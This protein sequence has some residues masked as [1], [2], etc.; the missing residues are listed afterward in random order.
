MV[1]GKP[2]NLGL[3]VIFCGM[4]YGKNF[5]PREFFENR[6]L[7]VKKIMTDYDRWA[8]HKR[9][10]LYSASVWWILHRLRTSEPSGIRR[11]VLLWNFPFYSTLLS[12]F[13]ITVLGLQLFWLALSSTYERTRKL[14]KSFE[15]DVWLQY[16]TYRGFKW[17]KKFEVFIRKKFW[18][19]TMCIKIPLSTKIRRMFCAYSSWAEARF[20]SL[21]VFNMLM[22][23]SIRRSD[24]SCPLSTSSQTQKIMFHFV[25]KKNHDGTSVTNNFCD[26]P[27]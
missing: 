11:F 26:E 23:F 17:P 7:L 18:S 14:T 15:N 2:I 6:T 24:K 25:R 12:R 27:T 16:L 8:I 22:K 4:F 21:E 20:F 1:D 9:I 19:I 3:W 10:A 13:R 5:W